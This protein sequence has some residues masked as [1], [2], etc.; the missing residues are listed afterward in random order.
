MKDNKTDK[1][2]P[3]RI[4]KEKCVLCGTCVALFPEV[5]KFS[6]DMTEIIIDSSAV[7]DEDI[8]KLI[9]VCPTGAISKNQ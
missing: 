8:D 3:I 5:F 6:D 4:E 7:R 2:C 1:K 9:D